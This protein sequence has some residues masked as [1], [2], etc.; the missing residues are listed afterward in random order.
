M[1]DEKV[2]HATRHGG[3]SLGNDR[4]PAVTNGGRWNAFVD[5]GVPEFRIL[6]KVLQH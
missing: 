2:V 3:L 1:I 6:G 5:V 4:L